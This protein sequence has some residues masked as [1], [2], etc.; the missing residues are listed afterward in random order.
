MTLIFDIL[1]IILLIH[2]WSGHR[3]DYFTQFVWVSFCF[4]GIN[5]SIFT[6]CLFVLV[7]LAIC[8]EVTLQCPMLK[9]GRRKTWFLYKTHLDV[10]FCGCVGDGCGC[11]LSSVLI[12]CV[13]LKINLYKLISIS[14]TY[15]NTTTLS[16]RYRY[17]SSFAELII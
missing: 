2:F 10:Y 17:F 8:G 15:Y 3:D 7:N 9:I 12:L 1:Q 14:T 16:L 11:L 13:D 6:Y 5:S 4:L